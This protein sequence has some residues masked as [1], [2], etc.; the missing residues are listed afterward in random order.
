MTEGCAFGQL[1]A[2]ATQLRVI[3]E[4]YCCA[5]YIFRVGCN[6]QPMLSSPLLH[7]AALALS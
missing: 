1:Q 4:R 7:P 3:P 5:A 2:V 6:V